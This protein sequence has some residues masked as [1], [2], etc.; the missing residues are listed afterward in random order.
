LT[1]FE[2]FVRSH[3][4]DPPARLLEVGCGEGELTTALAV[5]GF[6]VL[7]ID[8]AAPQG[9]LFRRITL[10][11]LEEPGGFDGVIAARSLHHIRDLDAALDKIAALLRPGGVI[12]VE[13][14][15]WDRLDQPTLEWLH[16]RRRALAAS[17]EGE[18]P[19]SIEALREEWDAEHLGLHGDA[20]LRRGLASRFEERVFVRTP[21]L[22]RSLDGV[23]TEVLEQALVDSGAIQ[24]LGFRF[25]GTPRPAAAGR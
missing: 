1:P 2:E 3:L 9:K 13:E 5:A 19:G 15:V 17:G 16:E 18:T 7:G 25:A 8:P 23:A 4:P 10:E 12:L 20:R 24:A 6:D 21:Y 14:F 11:E 22:Y